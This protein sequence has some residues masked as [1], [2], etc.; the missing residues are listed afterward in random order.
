[1]PETRFIYERID[2]RYVRKRHWPISWTWSLSILC[3]AGVLLGGIGIEG[4][5]RA[6][7]VYAHAIYSS[8]PLTRAH[9]MFADDCAQCH[10]PD[11]DSS[12]FWL[13]VQDE[14]CLKCHDTVAT[15]HVPTVTGE[16]VQSK[17]DGKPRVVKGLGTDLRMS[18]N[19]GSCHIEH[20]GRD[21]DLNKIDD[22]VCTRCH[23]NL[24]R[25]GYSKT[26]TG[27]MAGCTR[28]DYDLLGRP[29][30]ILDTGARQ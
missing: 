12:G 30:P 24:E 4:F 17:F 15:T 27:A 2:L 26:G 28:V 21:H 13:P 16:A 18:S 14:L 1:M 5:K 6:G 10:A 20:K 23:T 8:G 9:S 19:C 22:T 29:L 11:P 25:D 3:C 7:N